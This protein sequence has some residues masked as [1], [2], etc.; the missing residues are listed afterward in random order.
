MVSI[1]I[2]TTVRICNNENQIAKILRFLFASITPKI[3]A[4]SFDQWSPCIKSNTIKFAK[5]KERS[6]QKNIVKVVIKIGVRRVPIFIINYDTCCSYKAHL[7]CVDGKQK[8]NL[9]KVTNGENNDN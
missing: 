2:T 9:M 4:K 8:K 3:L 6:E 5:Q 7:D 1:K